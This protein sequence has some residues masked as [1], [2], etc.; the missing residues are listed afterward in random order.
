MSD[1]HRAPSVSDDIGTSLWRFFEALSAEERAA[2]EAL[3]ERDRR[4]GEDVKAE[5]AS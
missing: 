5:M 1:E 4:W 3:A 2:Y